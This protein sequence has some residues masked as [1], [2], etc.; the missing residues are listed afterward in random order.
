MTRQQLC[1]SRRTV[2]WLATKLPFLFDSTLQLSKQTTPEVC[3][4][5]TEKCPGEEAEKKDFL[6]A[7]GTFRLDPS[8]EAFITKTPMWFAFMS[9][10]VA[11][12][13]V[14]QCIARD[15]FDIIS[16]EDVDRLLPEWSQPQ[17][18]VGFEDRQP[19]LQDAKEK[20]TAGKL[21]SHISGLAY[22][23]HPGLLLQC[24]QWRG[25]GHRTMRG[26]I[27]DVFTMP[28]LFE[29]GTG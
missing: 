26:K 5:V 24:C 6:A 20:V 12:V 16:S 21:I 18:L 2:T 15:L 23:F 19:V 10:L 11:S 1:G 13:A 25:E 3:P 14:L 17:I 9:N 7:Y 29:P 4:K 27:P 28:L 22:G 8:L